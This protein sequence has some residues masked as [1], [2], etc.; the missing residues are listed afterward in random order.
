MR[1]AAGLESWI[2]RVQTLWGLYET[3]AR[4]LC[5]ELVLPCPTS[6]VVLPGPD[7]TP[8]FFSLAIH[9]VLAAASIPYVRSRFAHSFETA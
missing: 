4:G 7:R 2:V 9:Q 5:G 3:R 6:H 8:A 1:V